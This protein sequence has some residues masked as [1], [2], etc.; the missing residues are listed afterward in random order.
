MLTLVLLLTLNVVLW[1]CRVLEKTCVALLMNIE[2]VGCVV[3]D[4]WEILDRFT[5]TVLIKVDHR[6]CGGRRQVLLVKHARCLNHYLVITAAII[7]YRLQLLAF[8][9]LLKLF[10]MTS[11][12]TAKISMTLASA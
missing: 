4:V 12:F 5:V 2:L 3:H 7:L 1:Y 6:S 11:L 9:H 10:F 8:I